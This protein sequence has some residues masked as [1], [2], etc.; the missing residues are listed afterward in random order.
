M[1]SLQYAQTRNAWQAGLSSEGRAT[2]SSD[3]KGEMAATFDQRAGPTCFFHHFHHV[4]FRACPFLMLICST[5]LPPKR[6]LLKPCR[7]L[8]ASRDGFTLPPCV[9]VPFPLSFSLLSAGLLS[10]LRTA[11]VLKNR[12]LILPP[13]FGRSRA[14]P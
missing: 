2:R 1:G 7:P 5:E 4:V 11:R 3:L 9:L 14:V 6:V 13:R 10:G 12:I 8:V